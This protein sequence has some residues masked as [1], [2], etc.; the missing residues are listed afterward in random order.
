MKLLGIVRTVVLL[1]G[2]VGM[3][4]PVYHWNTTNMAAAT[5][6]ERQSLAMTCVIGAVAF[7]GALSAMALHRFNRQDVR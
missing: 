4:W 1:A 5:A 6:L 7:F 2:F 3:V